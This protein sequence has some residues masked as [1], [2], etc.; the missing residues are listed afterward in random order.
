MVKECSNCG[1]K[2]VDS[3]RFCG[4]CGVLLP[5]TVRPL[6][7]AGTR[8]K[9]VVILTLLLV[10]MCGVVAVA[11]LWFR[12]VDMELV[13]DGALAERGLPA[14]AQSSTPAPLLTTTVSVLGS[15]TPGIPPAPTTTMRSDL[16]IVAPTPTV[17][18]LIVATQTPSDFT[19][20]V[21][22]AV[23]TATS[24]PT[25]DVA[26]PVTPEPIRDTYVRAYRKEAVVVDGL[27]DEWS[28]IPAYIAD[29]AVYNASDWDGSEDLITYWQLG[30][31][32]E[33][34]Y[35]AATVEDD[36]H[37]QTQTGILTYMGDSLEMQIDTDLEGDADVA[38]L[39]P[40]DYQLLLS[41]GNFDDLSAS[42]ARFTGSEGGRIQEAPGHR[43]LIAAQQFPTGYT[44]E[45]A[46]P[47]SDL[48]VRPELGTLL[49]LALNA[50]DNDTPGTARQE[51]L[52]SNVP[53]RTLTDP[54]S[55][56]ILSLYS[57]VGETPA[58][59]RWTLAEQVDG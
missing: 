51:V 14:E 36:R 30:W 21:E 54:T 49:G 45:A 34:L 47:W 22:E 29:H 37:V 56:G 53:S 55:W 8:R 7:R 2:N 42:V 12:A 19:D 17:R 11:V 50:S 4:R 6:R 46:I 26:A 44:L 35:V 38:R 58:V 52:V 16:P 3:A 28:A 5:T 32:E 31:D 43:I 27:L 48:G 18:L 20:N 23:A 40:D 33:S 10:A 59:Q 25:K 13:T 24:L 15:P 9:G 57:S 1:H 39:S 41:P